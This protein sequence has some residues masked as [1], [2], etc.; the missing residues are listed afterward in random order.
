MEQMIAS[1]S[2]V[3]VH[4]LM[5]AG[6]DLVPLYA[7]DASRKTNE[8]LEHLAIS[9]LAEQAKLLVEEGEYNNL[10]SKAMT[11]R[12]NR[13]HTCSMCEQKHHG[14]V[15]C[16]LGWAC[17][18]T[19]VGRPETAI[20]RKMAI[21]VLGGG[22]SDADHHEDALSVQEA[23]LS[24]LR[25]LGVSDED[26]LRVQYDLALTYH[27]LGRP[28]ALQMRR[29][30]Y[31]GYL[32]LYGEE[33]RDTLI[34][35]DGYVGALIT[36]KRFKEVKSLLRRTMPVARRVLGDCDN[37]TVSMRYRYASAVCVDDDVTLDDFREAVATLEDVERIARRVFGGENPRTRGAEEA[38]EDARAA[39]RAREAGHRVKFVKPK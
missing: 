33:H 7:I 19:Y 5:A 26:I 12:W 18:K 14:V 38:L 1:W 28:E 22:L 16:A 9:C 39:L 32:R 21:G 10:G 11:E 37:T 36:L 27:A 8:A 24:M 25:R 31:S 2:M 4:A 3:M 13:W 6:P 23:E 17:W 29:D 35:A 15:M 30:V 20:A 34:A